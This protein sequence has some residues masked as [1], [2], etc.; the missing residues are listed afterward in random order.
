MRASGINLAPT[1][2]RRMVWR[3][4]P[5]TWLLGAAGVALC[6]GAAWQAQALVSQLDSTRAAL[7]RA[8]ARLLAKR[9]ALA[10]VAAPAVGQAQA[11]AVN[12]AVLR[13]NAPWRELLDALEAATPRTIALLALNPDPQK[14]LIKAQA[15]ART[16]ADMVAFAESLKRQG[17]FH[18]VRF[19][20]HATI[21]KDPNQPIQF[22]LEARWGDQVP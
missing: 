21:E 7:E 18:A 4:A 15:E 19:T 1:S 3:I 22:Q 11:D 20:R 9:P 17:V 12:A 14:R 16:P 5:L 6:A 10:V 13:L 2:L 8:D